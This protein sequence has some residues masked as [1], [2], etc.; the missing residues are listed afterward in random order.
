VL[1]DA[2]LYRAK[3][4]GRNQAVG[5]LPTDAASQNP[6]GVDLESVR[7]GKP[8]LARIVKTLRPESSEAPGSSEVVNK[9]EE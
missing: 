9:L 6:E 3:G 2:A 4:Q 7:D 8:P 5:I 1:A